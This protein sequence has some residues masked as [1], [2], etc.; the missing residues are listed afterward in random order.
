MKP[1]QKNVKIENKNK[2]QL[3]EGRP[4]ARF[5]PYWNSVAQQ[6]VSSS[7][8][9][10]NKT[11]ST[12]KFQPKTQSKS[13]RERKMENGRMIHFRL[14]AVCATKQRIHIRK[15]NLS[16]FNT[17]TQTGHGGA[18]HDRFQR[19][20]FG[21]CVFFVLNSFDTAHLFY[22]FPER[23]YFIF[24]LFCFS[25]TKL[26]FWIWRAFLSYFCFFKFE[27]TV[28]PLIAQSRFIFSLCCCCFLS[29]WPT[30]RVVPSVPKGVRSI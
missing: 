8:K 27:F 25:S 21:P 9:N 20:S 26:E 18:E 14:S 1:P 16:Q 11:K 23:N 17:H 30:V 24:I 5:R 28:L 2:K 4:G 22:L 10:P 7:K 15:K 29:L 6:R 13:L 19:I 12:K 3:R